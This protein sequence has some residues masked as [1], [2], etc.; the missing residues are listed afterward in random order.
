VP[1]D[2]QA[3]QLID[4]THLTPVDV[5]KYQDGCAA[6]SLDPT[7]AF[8]TQGPVDT[9]AI[10]S[11]INSESGPPTLPSS[12]SIFRTL[13]GPLSTV[14]PQRDVDPDVLVPGIALTS[15]P[16]PGRSDTPPTD[17]VSSLAPPAYR[18]D[19]GTPGPGSLSPD[20]ATAISLAMPQQL[21]APE[22]QSQPEV[23]VPDVT[24]DDSRC[25]VG[26]A[27]SSHDL[28]HPCDGK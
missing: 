25:A 11:M 13:S 1:D 23:S 10:S 18:T 12:T 26:A 24:K 22:R 5:E 15:L 6:A 28:D 21:N 7:T 19:Q 2:P 20:S 3:T 14:P 27:P 9:L 8:A 4:S 17:L 16:K